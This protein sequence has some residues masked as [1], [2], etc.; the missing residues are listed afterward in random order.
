MHVDLKASH[1][2][3]YLDDDTLT[4]AEIPLVGIVIAQDESAPIGATGT[5]Y[6]I[7]KWNDAGSSIEDSN[8]SDVDDLITLLSS[9]TLGDASSNIITST[10]QFTAS[11]GIHVEDGDLTFDN[12]L[13]NDSGFSVDSSGNL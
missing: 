3:P 2:I 9:A 8:I 5:Q 1:G 6:R 13:Y 7:L 12:N 11:N 10:G 4:N